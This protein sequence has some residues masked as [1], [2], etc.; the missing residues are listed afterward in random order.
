MLLRELERVLIKQAK[1]TVAKYRD[2]QAPC[3]QIEF[4]IRM[5]YHGN[6]PQ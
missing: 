1:Q 6:V 2:R 5:V 3:D 4:M